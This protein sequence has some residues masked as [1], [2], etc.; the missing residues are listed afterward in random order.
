MAAKQAHPLMRD[1]AA[2][3]SPAATRLLEQAAAAMARKQSDAAETALVGVLALVP[4]NVEAQ[5]LLGLVAQLRGDYREAVAILRRALASSPDDALIHMNLV[6]RCMPPASSST[7]W[8][9]CNRPAILRP[10]S[11]RPGSISARC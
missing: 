1:R 2:G 11:P 4:G 8:R 10:I 3:L 7:P 6:R 5:R 9:L